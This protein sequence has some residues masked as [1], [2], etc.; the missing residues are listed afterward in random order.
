MAYSLHTLNTETLATYPDSLESSFYPFKGNGEDIQSETVDAEIV[1]E[2]E[3]V[4]EEYNYVKPQNN[5]LM[6]GNI[7][8]SDD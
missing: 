6:E 8:E 5:N 7:R 3:V 2:E 1:E 4:E